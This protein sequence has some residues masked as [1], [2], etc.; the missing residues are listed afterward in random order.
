MKTAADMMPETGQSARTLGVRTAGRRRDVDISMIGDVVPGGG[1][2]SVSPSPPENLPEHRRP[3]KFGGIGKDYVWVLE[4]D[5][6]PPELVYR[7]D[8]KDPDRH[9]FI[10]PSR[11]MSVDDYLEAL[12]ATRD[13]WRIF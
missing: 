6:L 4:T 7:P 3:G 9:G 2:M 8:P 12:Q 10:E 13:L 1:G 11:T 5:E